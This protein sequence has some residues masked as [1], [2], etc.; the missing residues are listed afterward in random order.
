MN[1]WMVGGE[2]MNGELM[3]GGD[4]GDS[5]RNGGEVSTKSC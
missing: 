3:N 4:V 5:D 2:W 1:W